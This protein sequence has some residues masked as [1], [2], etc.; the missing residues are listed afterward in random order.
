MLPGDGVEPLEFSARGPA[1]TGMTL[2]PVTCVVQ[3]ELSVMACVCSVFLV[4]G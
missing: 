1:V 3:I 4:T 2:R